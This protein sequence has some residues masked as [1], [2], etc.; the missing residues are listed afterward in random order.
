M[1]RQD[2]QRVV[3]EAL[4]GARVL[5]QPRQLLRRTDACTAIG[6]RDV[7][8]ALEAEVG[9]A[10]EGSGH[11][12]HTTRHVCSGSSQGWSAGEL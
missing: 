3:V 8:R 2:V 4:R 11:R 1:R 12:A 6:V 10:K 9:N 5:K 7:L